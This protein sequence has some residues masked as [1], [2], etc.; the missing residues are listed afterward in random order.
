MRKQFKLLKAIDKHRYE[1]QVDNEI[2]IVDLVEIDK[3]TTT[4]KKFRMRSGNT[5]G[6]YYPIT[7]NYRV[8]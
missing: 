6:Y 8:A 4:K 1:A 7:G 3:H 2:V 5:V